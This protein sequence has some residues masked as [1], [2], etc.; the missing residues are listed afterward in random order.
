MDTENQNSSD[1]MSEILRFKMRREKE[2]GK[3]VKKPVQESL[4]F[5][6]LKFTMKEEKKSNNNE[7][8]V[9]SGKPMSQ[10]SSKGKE[11]NKE[12]SSNKGPIDVKRKKTDNET[13]FS[14]KKEKNKKVKKETANN[15]TTVTIPK[16]ISSKYS[17]K[18]GCKFCDIIHI[19]KNKLIY[20][21]DECAAFHDKRKSSAQEHI[22][23]CPK[24]HI[25]NTA[26]LV[27]DDI[28]LLK[29]LEEV[30]KKILLEKKATAAL[31]FGYHQP[32]MNSVDHLH[33]HGFMLPLTND[34]LDKVIY[35]FKL[36]STQKIIDNLNLGMPNGVNQKYLSDVI[37]LEEEENI[38]DKKE[39]SSNGISNGIS[40]GKE[41]IDLTE[42]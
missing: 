23:I 25:V 37:N 4:S 19:S 9:H 2:Q 42:E 1:G 34:Y 8:V 35:G 36:A 22:L 33:L 21:D 3:E 7:Q 6:G 15:S 24:R 11:E 32:P 26:H 18:I 40:N 30:G 29:H 10:N 39:I 17:T 28:P 14:D 12:N 16:D 31:R 27:K 13:F 20:E 38:E 5:E 41:I